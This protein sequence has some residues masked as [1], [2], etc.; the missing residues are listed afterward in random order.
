MTHKMHS[1]FGIKYPLA[2]ESI[3]L[4]DINVIYTEIKIFNF[5]KFFRY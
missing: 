5:I 1:D 4:D 2:K 3:N